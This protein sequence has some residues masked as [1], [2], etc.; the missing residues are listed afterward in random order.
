MSARTNR[1]L[2]TTVVCAVAVAVLMTT[3][4][5]ATPAAAADAPPTG[6]KCNT[7][8]LRTS[9]RTWQP[10]TGSAV[11]VPWI[12]QGVRTEFVN[13]NADAQVSFGAE[14]RIG[15]RLDDGPVQTPGAQHFATYTASWQMRQNMVSIEVPPG[16]G[17][18]ID[19]GNGN[20]N[21][22]V[23]AYWRLRGHG[24]GMVAG[25][26]LVVQTPSLG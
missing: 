6:M 14:I 7:D 13:F 17:T 5:T 25:R 9:S 3:V 24:V 15:Y 8:V 11:T 4:S 16:E 21:H 1:P 12:D 26:C 10:V 22:I 19:D 18:G 20:R 2:K 23:Q